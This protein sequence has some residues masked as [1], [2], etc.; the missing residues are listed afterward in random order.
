MSDIIDQIINTG[1]TKELI[2]IIISALPIIELRG[3]LPVAINVFHIPW[4]WALLLALLGNILP[5]PFLLLLLESITRI[6]CKFTLGERAINWFL[7]RT[8]R[9]SKVVEKY[10]KIGL[11]LFVAVPLPVT[12]AWTGS[13][14]AFL[15]GIKFTHALIAIFCGLIIAGTIVTCLCLLGWTGAVIAGVGLSI[16]AVIGWWKT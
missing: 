2:V 11:T 9:R 16:I 7:E 6:L 15:F 3:S 5:V 12:G 4:Y 13:I 8:R 14:A 1:T 10:E